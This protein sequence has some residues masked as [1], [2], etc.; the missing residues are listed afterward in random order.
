MATPREDGFAMPGEFAPHKRTLMG[1]PTRR[2]LWGATLAQAKSDYADVANA[3]A[4]FEPVA[5]V[6]KPEDA[7]EARAALSGNVEIIEL[8]ID[9]SWLRDNGPIFLLDGAGNRAASAFGFNA[10]GEKFTPYDE[11]ARLARRL[12]RRWDVP[13][14]DPDM[15]LEG[16][17]VHVDGAG[18]VITTEQCLLHPSRNPGMSREE[19]EERVLAYLGA[20]QMLW[21]GKGLVEDRDTDG[22][23]DLIVQVT[24][25]RAIV[26]QTVPDANPNAENCRENLARARGAGLAVLE[27]EHLH[28]GEVAGDPVTMSY[29]NLYLC[30]GAAIVPTSGVP[31]SDEP[32]L[33]R[34]AEVV[35]ERE[36]VA[37]PG[38]VLA[39]GG[40][41]PHCITQQVPAV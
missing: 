17:S 26:L 29:L 24:G 14:Y 11:D 4:A 3:I 31:A 1:W 30:N 12:M 27:F 2:E 40:G 34:L 39:Y 6:A 10:W 13:C 19:I 32:A 28:Y 18:L 25:P 41:G 38:M 37:V 7:E 16:G 15:V 9:D 35:P 36:I 23:V 8:P 21:L 20:D 33:A 5:M 22:H